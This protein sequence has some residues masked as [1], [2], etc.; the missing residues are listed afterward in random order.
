LTSLFIE[1]IEDSPMISSVSTPDREGSAARPIELSPR[2]FSSGQL[3]GRLSQRR[4]GPDVRRAL[5]SAR[6]STL[7]KYLTP[8]T[9]S[10]TP[11]YQH[12]VPKCSKME[13]VP[14]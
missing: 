1:L 9:L 8:P 7:K 6:I 14:K 11:V 2:Q 13:G 12:S 3:R 5:R 4:L 10:E